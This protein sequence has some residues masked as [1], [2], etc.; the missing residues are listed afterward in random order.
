MKWHILHVKP[1]C[2]KKMADYCHHY[3]FPCY[4]PLRKECKIYQRRKVT[5]EKPLF[6]GYLFVEFDE[7]GRELILK[8]NYVVR[9]LTPVNQLQLLF[10]LEQIRTALAVDPALSATPALKRGSRV[11]ITAGPFMGIE[12]IVKDAKGTAKVWLNIEM[13]GQAV[14][15]EAERSSLEIATE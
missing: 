15:V 11:R 12:G 5:V 7:P 9:I 1:R 3:P 13:I 4:L 14:T 8:T 2:E 10:E 6:P